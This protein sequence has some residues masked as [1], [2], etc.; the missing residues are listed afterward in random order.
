MPVT[1]FEQ[2][3]PVQ[4]QYLL[5][6]AEVAPERASV[7]SAVVGCLFEQSTDCAL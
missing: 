3:V 7:P 5:L 4:E 6:E 1:A 2:L